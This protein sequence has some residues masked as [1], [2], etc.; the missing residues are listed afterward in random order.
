MIYLRFND[1]CQPRYMSKYS[2]SCDL[3]S[4]VDIVI[5]PQQRVAVPTGVWIDKI[6]WTAVPLNT[7]PEIQ[8]RARSGLSLKHGI[9]LAN[10]IGTI[11]VD[12]PDEICVILI[13][14]STTPFNI[15]KGDR[16]AQMCIN[17]CYKF[18]QISSEGQRKGGLGS[19][20]Y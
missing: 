12:Y 17:L 19:T 2:S 20:G 8:I 16:I 1:D 18:P 9:C 3:I 4:R 14:L 10:G 5:E 6:D 7:I 13:N 11:D 15:K